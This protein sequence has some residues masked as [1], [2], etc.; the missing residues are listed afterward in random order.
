MSIRLTSPQVYLGSVVLAASLWL[1]CSAQAGGKERG[2]AIEFSAP[3]SDEATTNLNQL[4]SKKDGLK[5]LEEDLYKPLQSFGPSS[6]LDG[7]AVPPPRAPAAPA[8][9]SKRVKELLERRKNWVF[10]T[11]EDMLATPTLEDVLKTPQF[12]PDGR[13]KTELP[14]FERYYGHLAAKRPGVAKSTQPNKEDLFGTLGKSTSRD[15]RAPREDSNLPSGVR[16]RAEELT[17]LSQPGSIDSP[18]SQDV[19]HGNLSDTFGL[20][21]NALSKQ[22][23]QAHKKYMDNYSSILDSSLHSPSVADPVNLLSTVAAEGAS[24]A[25]KPATG[26][27][28]APSLA[29]RT[30]LEVQMDVVSPRL[31]PPGLPDVNSHALG[32]TRPTPALLGAETIRVAPP[33]PS[34]AAPKRSF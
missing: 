25:A 32:Q 7:V 10:M 34:F 30:V 9:Q 16:E 11:P 14:A 19:T 31:G 2:R 22:Q 6:S 1:V 5:Q 33:A 3:R 21:N 26:L 27:P 24:P 13:E 18:F 29:P 20:G 12:G 28:G 17:R 23:V 4:T 15:E 8:I